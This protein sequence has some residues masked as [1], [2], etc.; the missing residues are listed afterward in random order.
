[1]WTVDAGSRPHPHIRVVRIDVSNSSNYVLLDEP[2]IWH[3]DYAYAYPDASPNDNGD[4]GISL[5]RGGGTINPGHVVGVLDNG[6]NRWTLQGTRNGTNGPNGNKW[7]DYVTCRNHSNP[8][9]SG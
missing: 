9:N 3:N 5:F 8:G 6:S 4:V 7:G 1:M 2:D